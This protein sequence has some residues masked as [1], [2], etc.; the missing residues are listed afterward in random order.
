MEADDGAPTEVLHRPARPG[1]GR[2]AWRAWLPEAAGAVVMLVVAFFTATT[3]FRLGTAPVDVAVIVLPAVAVLFCRRQPALALGLMWVATVLE[4]YGRLAAVEIVVAAAVVMF[5]CARWGRVGTVVAAGLSIP[6]A[7]ALIGA[8]LY[9]RPHY[10]VTALGA[11]RGVADV[12][13]RFGD[14]L[15]INTVTLVFGLL[16]LPL[17]LPWVVG[18]AVRY[19]D[20]A[21]V[22]DASRAAAQEETVQARE[23]ARLRAE[24]NRL[25]RDVHD[26]VGHSLAVILAQAESAQYLPDDD[27]AA[28]KKTMSTIASSARTSLRDVRQVLSGESDAPRAGGLDTLIEG[29]R[30]SGHDILAAEDGPPQP[31]PPELEVVAFR[32]LQEMLTN[33]I[34]HGRRDQ[35]IRV[36]RQWPAPGGR[37]LRIEVRNAVDV[38]PHAV[39]AVGGQGLDGMR[40]RLEAVGGRLDTRREAATFTATAWV[41][42][43]AA[44]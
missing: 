43:R 29:A 21:T 26:V 28:L 44:R 12:A 8:L 9:F 33:A 30:T 13:V 42:V 34:K 20:R 4:A 10:V 27:P 15:Q 25:A 32:V 17:L 5:G 23:I 3:V 2:P 14:S 35:P 31:L 18:L 37:E 1:T 7:L 40:R 36:G 41:P 19:R 22:S 24:Q 16:A 11:F 38:S 39:P 6:V